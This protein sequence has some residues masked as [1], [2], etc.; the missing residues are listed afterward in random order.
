[1]S[2]STLYI[3]IF[4]LWFA[5]L[6]T[7][8]SFAADQPPN[9]LFILADDVGSDAI[10][11][12]GGQSHPTPHIDALAEGGMRFTQGYAMPVCHPS[13]M[14][15]MTGRYPF[16]FGKAGSK[17]GDFPDDGEGIAIG[18]RLKQGGYATAVAGKWQLCFMKDDP[19]QP[20][21]VGFDEWL[22]FGWHEGGR[23][24]DP[25][26][27]QNGKVRT[28]T[29]GKYGPDLYVE[30]LIDFMR[31]NHEAG[32]PFFAYYPMALCHD[33]T[34][35]LKDEHVAYYKDGRWMTYAEMISS[36]DDMV[37]RLVAALDDMGI[38]DNTLILFTTDNGTPSGSYLRVGEDGKMERPKVYSV[39]NN[40]V[41]PGGK[42]KL[43][44]TG[45]RVPYIANWPGKIAAGAVVNE[46]VDMTDCLPTF[47]EVAGLADDGVPRDGLS[48]APVLFGDGE[49][50]QGREWIY[51]ELRG[52][53]CVRSKH[54]KLYGTGELYH[55]KAD[56]R[57][58]SPIP[59]DQQKGEAAE[60]YTKLSEVLASM[61]GPLEG[62]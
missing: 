28:D 5:I 46:M 44:D 37:G 24:H 43:D 49:Q 33:V 18:D 10:G 52:N 50:F 25:L 11:C 30:F 6:T 36:M 13:R 57:E 17:W 19:D 51:I 41:V 29:K 15:I 42:G 58:Q 12:Y 62:Q 34:D 27:Y 20:R 14:C 9:I 45:T 7:T 3:W 32:K 38:R 4:S 2:S 54:W 59:A 40:Q 56:P 39:Q 26:L 1:M 53:R 8:T 31:R 61:E 22:L 16:R 21:R 55:V 47:A 48:F 35:D 23:Y 60:Q